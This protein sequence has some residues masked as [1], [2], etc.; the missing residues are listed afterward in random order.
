VNDWIPEKTNVRN[1]LG[2]AKKKELGV[3]GCFSLVFGF[4]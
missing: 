3:G 2:K 1:L 4:V